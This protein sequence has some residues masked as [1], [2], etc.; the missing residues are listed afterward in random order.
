MIPEVGLRPRDI[1]SRLDLVQ[2]RVSHPFP[3]VDIGSPSLIET[4][5]LVALG[6]LCAPSHFLEFGTYT[7]YTTSV[8]AEN[9]EGLRVSTVDLPR[10]RAEGF[11]A[12]RALASGVENDA[13]LIEARN[14]RGTPYIDV[15]STKVQE[16]IRQIEMDSTSPDFLRSMKGEQFD[17]FFVDGGHSKPVVRSDYQVVEELASDRSISVWHDY[18]SALHGDVKTVLDSLGI[19]ERSARVVGTSLLIVFPEKSNFCV[20][21]IADFSD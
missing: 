1:L 5:L 21:D 18:G 15:L 2:E 9:F 7:G 13:F 11:D 6:K 16:R 14:L 8:M 19:G 20:D 17:F 3:P 12:K 4:F 10:R